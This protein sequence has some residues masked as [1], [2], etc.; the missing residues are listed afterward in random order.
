VTDAY[1]G[2]FLVDQQSIGQ[3]GIVADVVRRDVWENNTAF[4]VSGISTMDK[5]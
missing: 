3:V 5:T 4:G 2:R 1:E